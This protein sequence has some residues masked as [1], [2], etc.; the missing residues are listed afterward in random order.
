MKRKCLAVGIILLF[1][2]TCIIPTI[3][4][5]MKK[6]S[7]P[8]KT[9]SNYDYIL[10]SNYEDKMDRTNIHLL[11]RMGPHGSYED[12]I[13]SRGS[14]PFSIKRIK[15]A[16]SGRSTP[17][18]IIFISSNL[19]AHIQNEIN[20]YNAT[21]INNGYDTVVFSMAGGTAEDMKNQI[22]SYWNNG[23]N[24][25]GAVLFGDLPVA[26]F[27]HEND[28]YGPE[29]FP[30]DLFL[31]DL[32]GTWVDTNHD[33]I[34]DNHTN[35]TGNTAPEIYVGRIDAS[36]IPGDE[37]AITKNYL[38]KDYEFWTEHGNTTNP[39]LTYTDKDW[40]NYSEF[41]NEIRFAYPT[42]QAI[43]YPNVTRDDYI[44]T[45]LPGVYDF[46]QLSC[47]SSSSGHY[48]TIGGEAYS[49]DVRSAPP[50]S[51]FYNL[52]C[53]DAVRFTDGN[54][55]GDA[56][57]LNTSTPSLVVIGSTKTGSMLDFKHF[58]KPL[59]Q[60]CSFGSAFQQWFCAEYPY[61]DN[62]MSWFYGMTI[63]G[64]PTLVPISSP[65][66]WADA[67][68]PYET[69]MNHSIDFHG[70]ADGGEPPYTWHWDFGDGNTSEQQNTTHAYTYTKIPYTVTLT[71][72]DSQGNQTYDVTTATT[73][74]PD[75][76]P[77]RVTLVSPKNAVYIQNSVLF[78][79]FRPVVIG[80]TTIEVLASDNDSGIDCV[81]FYIDYQL[82]GQIMDYSPDNIY[83]WFWTERTPLRFRHIITVIAR[84][85]WGN[86][87]ING[88]IVW[89]F[90]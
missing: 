44:D 35:G 72:T 9:P 5:N 47:H 81:Q 74:G 21:L 65:I 28:F 69:W 50:R 13:K 49:D 57:I 83:R 39:A 46:I 40:A 19:F 16:Q 61:N 87:A 73:D 6:P 33:G 64:D 8:A 58:Y 45:Q 48:F 86:E 2:G 3:A 66:F 41:R 84:D 27:H 59:G 54:C 75:T 20:E 70:S 31:M 4:Q 15:E 88:T 38:Q 79:F 71:V 34:Y 30:C 29:E 82:K 51:L 85:Y 18:I 76:Y 37:I 56:Y 7:L 36:K 63:L 89:R 32:D 62:D 26:W 53:C 25:T 80:G 43:W 22:L 12:Y 10:K 77:P 11:E 60:C 24:V 1:V 23:Y 14:E 90:F 67:N 17:L 78:P 52:F 68:G 55:L 42:Y